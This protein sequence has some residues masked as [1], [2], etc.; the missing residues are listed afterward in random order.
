MNKTVTY[1]GGYP[2]IKTGG[3]R[4]DRN[5]PQEVPAELADAL[6]KAQTDDN[7]ATRSEPLFVIE[8]AA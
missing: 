4:F 5:V 8:D 2:T 6:A 1:V 7:P 3:Y